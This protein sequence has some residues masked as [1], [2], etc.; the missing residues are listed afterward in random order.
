MSLSFCL[1]LSLSIFGPLV[2]CPSLCLSFHH[3]P[4]FPGEGSLH[5]FICGPFTRPAELSH[6]ALQALGTHACHGLVKKT[7]YEVGD[8]RIQKEEERPDACLLSALK[9]LFQRGQA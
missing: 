6:P 9:G 8:K 5:L 3:R 1:F 4:F 7:H 2:F